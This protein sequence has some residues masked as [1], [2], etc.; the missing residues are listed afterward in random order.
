MAPKKRSAEGEAAEAA[1]ELRRSTRGGGHKASEPKPSSKPKSAGKAKK[2]KTDEME[3]PADAAGAS[4]GKTNGDAQENG[5]ETK[6]DAIITDAEK[7]AKKEGVE[8]PQ[9][10]KEA[11]QEKKGK[12]IEVGE[13]LPE[14]ITLKVRLE[15]LRG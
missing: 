3:K 15:V 9:E 11:A 7:D 1:G 5:T 14:G 13:T 4:E 8:V 12:R 2:A 10:N 6:A